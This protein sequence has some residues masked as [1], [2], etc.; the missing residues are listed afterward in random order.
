MMEYSKKDKSYTVEEAKLRMAKYCTYQDRCHFEVEKKLKEMRMIPAAQEQIIVFLMQEGFLN[1]ERFTRSYIRGKFY[2]KSWGKN[3]IIQ[4][5]RLKR[6]PHSLIQLC[7]DEIKP[8]DYYQSCL[9]LVE[10][11]LTQLN[12]QLNLKNQQKIQ[13][14]LYQKGFESDLIYECL[15]ELRLN[16]S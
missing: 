7:M 5:L 15:N 6:I 12:N 8:N 9:T 1:E 10:K 2:Y 4:Q 14:Y 13:S 16:K 11:K 3:K